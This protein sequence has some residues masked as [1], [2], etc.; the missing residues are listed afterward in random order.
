MFRRYDI[1]GARLAVAGTADSLVTQFI[2]LATDHGMYVVTDEKTFAMYTVVVRNLEENVEVVFTIQE[3]K[4]VQ[5]VVKSGEPDS[6]FVRSFS[7]QLEALF[8][9]NGLKYRVSQWR[10]PGFE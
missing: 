3:S 5:V 6:R 7:S 8:A 1:S 9:V 4:Y 10:S 2:K